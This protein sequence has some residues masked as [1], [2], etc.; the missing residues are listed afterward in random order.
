MSEKFLAANL[1]GIDPAETI[2]HLLKLS[3]DAFQEAQPDK[4]H[5]PGFR[6]PYKDGWSLEAISNQAHRRALIGFI[7]PVFGYQKQKTKEVDSQQQTIQ[8][9][10]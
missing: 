10:H 5:R 1:E 7:R 8:Q 3:Y 4:K 9:R 6:S 2:H